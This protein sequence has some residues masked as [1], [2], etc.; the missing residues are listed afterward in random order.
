MRSMATWAEGGERQQDL[1]RLLSPRSDEQAGADT[2]TKPVKKGSSPTTQNSKRGFC[3][4]FKLMT[5][6]A[7]ASWCGRCVATKAPPHVRTLDNAL[8]GILRRR[9]SRPSHCSAAREWSR[10]RRAAESACRCCSVSKYKFRD[11]LRVSC[12]LNCTADG[13]DVRSLI[14]EAHAC[15]VILPCAHVR[16]AP[17]GIGTPCR[18]LW[19]VVLHGVWRRQ[20]PEREASD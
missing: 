18:F 11:L 19:G 3:C 9:S 13:E 1:G 4:D 20:V 12:R 17:S 16:N 15:L 14:V 8:R 5:Y 7:R 2:W 6:E 10:T